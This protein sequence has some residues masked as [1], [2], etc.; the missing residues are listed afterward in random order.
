MKHQHIYIPILAL[1]FL[2]ACE[3]F[4]DQDLEISPP[5]YDKQLAIRQFHSNLDDTLVVAVSRN[6]GILETIDEKDYAVTD[7]RVEWIEDGHSIQ[8]LSLDT[9][10][11]P[12]AYTMVLAKPLQSGKFYEIRV[13]HP[14]F[15]TISAQQKMPSLVPLDSVIYEKD[16]ALSQ[17]GNRLNQVRFYFKDPPGEENYY[18]VLLVANS[19]CLKYLRR[20]PQTNKFVYD[21]LDCEISLFLDGA[22]HPSAHP[23]DYSMLITDKTFNGSNFT[24]GVNFGNWFTIKSIKAVFRTLTRENYLYK[25]SRN[26]FEEAQYNPLSDP[27]ILYSNVQNGIGVFGLETEQSRLIK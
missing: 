25:V 3:R 1:F 13:S 17:E 22:T 14:D 6:F 7:A 2:V 4:L 5:K 16:G 24:F 8:V 21:T 9:A 10:F 18:E 15:P 11:K 12:S 27:V 20:D 26:R 23:G 19:T